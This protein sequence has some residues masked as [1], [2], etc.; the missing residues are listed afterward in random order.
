[1]SRKNGRKNICLS[2]DLNSR[3]VSIARQAAEADRMAQSTRGEPAANRMEREGIL[4]VRYEPGY[5][6][7][8]ITALTLP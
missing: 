7:Q 1:M 2:S 4:I 8:G 6:D 5:I 3:I